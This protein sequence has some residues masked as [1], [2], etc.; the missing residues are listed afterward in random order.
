MRRDGMR[1]SRLEGRGT[2][3]QKLWTSAASLAF[4]F[5]LFTH[6]SSYLDTS[7]FRNSFVIDRLK[8][9]YRITTF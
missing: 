1:S 6:I 8:S 9:R 4:S 2:S 3:Y 7:T 5:F